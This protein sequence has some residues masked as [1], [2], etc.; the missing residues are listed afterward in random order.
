MFPPKG[1]L[2]TSTVSKEGGSQSLIQG[3]LLYS[4]GGIG[5][6]SPVFT[7]QHIFTELGGIYASTAGRCHIK[8]LLEQPFKD[9]EIFGG[10]R[11]I[12]EDTQDS[13]H[14][15]PLKDPKMVS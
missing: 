10:E 6:W 12:L 14:N 7:T 13:I 3:F 8:S 15:V 2:N 4:D 5:L 9:L 11:N 1:P